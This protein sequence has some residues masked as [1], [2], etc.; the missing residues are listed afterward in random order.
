M[1]EVLCVG[2]RAGVTAMTEQQG[3]SEINTEPV[4]ADAGKKLTFSTASFRPLAHVDV[5]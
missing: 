2:R 4:G 1:I 3:E 5:L